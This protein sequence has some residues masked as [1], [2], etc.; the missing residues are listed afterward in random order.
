MIGG[1]LVLTTSEFPNSAAARVG[2]GWRHGTRPAG[3]SFTQWAPM[4]PG[5]GL[6]GYRWMKWT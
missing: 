6:G 3:S 4:E 1:T 2:S 5:T